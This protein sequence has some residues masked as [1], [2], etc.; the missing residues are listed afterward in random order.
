MGVT[1][2]ERPPAPSSPTSFLFSS[3]AHLFK[4]IQQLLRPLGE[5]L[6]LSFE[7]FIHDFS[8]HL[9]FASIHWIRFYF[10][11]CS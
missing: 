11:F 6:S 5:R 8:S 7:L 1:F 3:D 9:D 10:I 4:C 2:L